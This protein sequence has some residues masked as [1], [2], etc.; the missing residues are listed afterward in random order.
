MFLPMSILSEDVKQRSIKDLNQESASF[1]WFQVLIK[2]LIDI[3]I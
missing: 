3:K 2:I 1:M